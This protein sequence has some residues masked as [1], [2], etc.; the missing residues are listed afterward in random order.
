MEKKP[1]RIINKTLDI[2][3]GNVKS[4]AH[5]NLIDYAI[6][7]YEEEFQCNLSQYKLQS[8]I[9]REGANIKDKNG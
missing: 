7:D 5:L 2:L 9:L 3:L 8:K 1:N 6:K 4:I